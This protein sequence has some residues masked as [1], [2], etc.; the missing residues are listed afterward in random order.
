MVAATADEEMKDEEVPS[1]P[2]QHAEAQLPEK[3][4]KEPTP[5]AEKVEEIEQPA[6]LN[7]EVAVP[8]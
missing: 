7:P 4:S 6:Q 1:L 3:P 5:V 2:L 8:E